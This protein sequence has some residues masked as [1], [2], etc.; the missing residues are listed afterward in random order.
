MEVENGEVDLNGKC[1]RVPLS[2]GHKAADVYIDLMCSLFTVSPNIDG[3][4]S[5]R[6]YMINPSTIENIQP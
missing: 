1:K 6:K 3:N 5:V 4:Y 2:D